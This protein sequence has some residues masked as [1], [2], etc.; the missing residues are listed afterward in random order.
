MKKT[1]F[2]SV[3]LKREGLRLDYYIISYMLSLEGEN[4]VSYGIEISQ[5][6][7]KGSR[8]K[9]MTVSLEDIT[10]DRKKIEEFIGELCEGE[11][12]PS[13]LIDAANDKIEE[14][15]AYGK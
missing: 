6:P 8:L 5:T 2:K 11:F 1:L 7:L 12:D 9:A 4:L 14:W 10:P 3:V 15:S 13:M